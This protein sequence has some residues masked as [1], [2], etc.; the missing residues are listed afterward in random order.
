MMRNAI[1]RGSSKRVNSNW[2]YEGE[3]KNKRCRGGGGRKKFR[4]VSKWEK[5]GEEDLEGL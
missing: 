5:D 3:I 2:V 1:I 4:I